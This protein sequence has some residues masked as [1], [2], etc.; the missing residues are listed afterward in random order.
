M[1][2]SF[3]VAALSGAGGPRYIVHVALLISACTVEH[4]TLENHSTANGIIT[5]GNMELSLSHLETVEGTGALQQDL[6]DILSLH[7]PMTAPLK[8]KTGPYDY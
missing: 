2:R 8:T 3:I 7:T 5:N 1:T 4:S 6:V